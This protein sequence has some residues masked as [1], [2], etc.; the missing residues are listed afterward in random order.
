[1]YYNFDVLIYILMKDVKDRGELRSSNEIFVAHEPN[2]V[3]SLFYRW[4]IVYFS[5]KLY[6][7]QCDFHGSLS[8]TGTY[9]I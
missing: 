1:M 6:E 3:W 7:F 8:T 4:K 9:V 5:P 2:V